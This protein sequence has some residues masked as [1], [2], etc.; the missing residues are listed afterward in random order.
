MGRR[1]R[2]RAPSER[3]GD[4]AD[5]LEE[6]AWQL[7]P[8]R[9]SRWL[10]DRMATGMREAG[11]LEAASNASTMLMDLSLHDLPRLLEPW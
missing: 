3:L 1:S 5:R 7:M 4:A 6:Y 2:W 8:N 9:K 11:T 10:L